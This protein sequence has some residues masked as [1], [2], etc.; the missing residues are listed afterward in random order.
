LAPAR[1]SPT[2]SSLLCTYLSAVLLGGLLLN[3]ILGWSWTDPA[4]ALVIAG[5]AVREGRDAWRGKGCCAVPPVTA[6]AR[7]A[8]AGATGCGCGP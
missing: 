2:P 5:L 3:A 8:G 1:P 7:P 4:A 6:S